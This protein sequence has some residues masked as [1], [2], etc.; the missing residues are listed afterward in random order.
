M[1]CLISN[2]FTDLEFTGKTQCFPLY[3]YE[4][5]TADTM[6]LFDTD[7][8]NKY[9]R[10][11]G[12]TDFILGQAQKLYGPKVTKE[13]IFYY[14]Y[15]F[16]HLPSYREEFAADLKKSLPRIMLVDEPK[17]FWQLSKAGRDLADIHLNYEH[18]PYPADVFV[19]GASSGNFKVQKMKFKSKEDK[20]VLIYNKDITISNIPP[21]AHEYIVN[22]RSP[23]EWIIDR[24]QVKQDK[25]SG[26]INDPNK[27]GEEHGNNRYI[28][29]L[30]LSCIT[31][32]I[33]TREIVEK[34][35]KINFY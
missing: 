7:T 12:I 17:T 15:G 5:N 4:E 24:Y 3:Y 28:L 8:T 27:W 1:S 30:I 33:K 10:K 20:S 11:D 6:S 14:V 23:L 35:P 32:S 22:G 13:D 21:K 9:T 19:D 16:L 31:V 29:D 34:L 25:A 2:T 26:I 18:Q